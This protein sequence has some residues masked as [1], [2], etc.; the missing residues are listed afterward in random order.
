MN[1][2]FVGL[3]AMGQLI[4]ARLMAAGWFAQARTGGGVRQELK[5]TGTDPGGGG[6]LYGIL[7]GFVSVLAAGA[8]LVQVSNPDETQLARHASTERT[9]FHQFDPGPSLSPDR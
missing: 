2:G 3:G 6:A 1:L 5:R 8:S 4:V 9:T 7:D